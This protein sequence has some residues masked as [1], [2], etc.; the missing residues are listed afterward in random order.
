MT[1]KTS[2][3]KKTAESLCRLP[4]QLTIRHCESLYQ[5]INKQFE[6]ENLKR[7]ILDLA[8]VQQ[9]DTAGLQ[10]I[11]AVKRHITVR[12][13][14]EFVLINV[15]QDIEQALTLL[16]LGFVIDHP[17]EVFDVAGYHGTTRVQIYAKAL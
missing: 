11:L 7:V 14:A 5:T 16:G 13:K 3:D 17:K 4:E 1:T 10:L 15:S 9:F 8:K 12:L 6:R 2:D